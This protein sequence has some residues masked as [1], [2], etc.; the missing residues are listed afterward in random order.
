MFNKFFSGVQKVVN[1]S[2]GSNYRDIYFNANPGDNHQCKGCGKALRKSVPYEIEID[3][4]VPKK[5]HGT[6]AIT[7][8]QT[9][10]KPCNLDKR[11]KI[12]KLTLDYS[13][14]ALLRELRKVIRY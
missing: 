13:G 2:A 4:I 11:A 10:C 7:N 8:L 12:N 1:N 5:A 3:H 9:L 6:N 14:A